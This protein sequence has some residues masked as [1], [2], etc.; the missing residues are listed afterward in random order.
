MSIIPSGLASRGQD[1][2]LD[3]VKGKV[4]G[5]SIQYVHAISPSIGVNQ[6]LIWPLSGNVT[7]NDTPTTLYLT[8]TDNADT[9]FVQIEWLDANYD[10]ITSLVQLSGH[11]PVAIGVGLRVNRA[12][13]VA[14]TATLGNVYIANAN[15]HTAGVPNDPT[16][17]V[18]YYDVATQ[19]RSMALYTVPNNH[20]AI[21][22]SGYFSSPKGRDNDFFWNVRNPN[23]PIPPI[24][25]NVVSV[26]QST[27]EIDFKY[28]N[29]PEKT[30]AYFTAKTE[31]STG[32]V[33]L[34]IPVLTINNDYF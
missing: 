24:N 7:F 19:T 31:A 20:T 28:T 29:I 17:I 2:L 3:V 9:Q 15:N 12:F 25:T 14:T 6:S 18:S 10:P 11:T 21:G 32:R 13:T 23:L 33:S 27:V 34:R 16:E 4:P 5:H 8:S 30:D 1:F 22:L 26:Y